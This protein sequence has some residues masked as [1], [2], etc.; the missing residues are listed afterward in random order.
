[1]DRPTIKNEDIDD[2]DFEDKESDMECQTCAG[3]YPNDCIC[4]V[5]D[6][7]PVWIKI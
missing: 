6:K 2:S 3:E 5:K 1:M 7:R 4:Y